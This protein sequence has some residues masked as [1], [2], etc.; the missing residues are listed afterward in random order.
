MR[1][2][3]ALLVA[4]CDPRPVVVEG[5][6][7]DPTQSEV[8]LT[9]V[10][11]E[12]PSDDLACREGT[13][14]RAA[15]NH[16]CRFVYDDVLELPSDVRTTNVQVTVERHGACRPLQARTVVLTDDGEVSGPLRSPTDARSTFI[17]EVV[18]PF[19]GE[20]VLLA[21][22]LAFAPDASCT[23]ESAHVTW[24]QVELVRGARR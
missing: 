12:L 14:W 21:V 7:L 4:A 9:A 5:Q 15:P 17:D 23:T 2:L 6:P 10:N 19:P 8:W 11:D 22:D 24:L 1:T 16:S 13:R 20:D 3:L 18:L